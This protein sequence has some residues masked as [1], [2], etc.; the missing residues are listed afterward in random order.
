MSAMPHRRRSSAAQRNDAM[1]HDC[2]RVTWSALTLARRSTRSGG[3]SRRLLGRSGRRS[4]SRRGRGGSRSHAWFTATVHHAHFSSAALADRGTH[5]G[6][7]YADAIDQLTA[8]TTSLANWN[9]RIVWLLKW[10]V[11]HTLCWG[12][13]T[14]R[15]RNDGGSDHCFLS[16]VTESYADDFTIGFEGRGHV[17]IAPHR[18]GLSEASH[19]VASRP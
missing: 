17:H 3:S 15:E 1:G 16:S 5:L 19:A 9:D 4:R 6:V 14:Q 11:R 8:Q 7:R 13:N 2:P 10:G 12:H 18:A